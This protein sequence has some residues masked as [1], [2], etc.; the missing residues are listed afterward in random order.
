MILFNSL[1]IF[2]STVG[3]IAAT[4]QDIVENVINFLQI[5]I[6]LRK[7]P[8]LRVCPLDHLIPSLDENLLIRN[9]L[10]FISLYYNLSHHHHYHHHHPVETFYLE[11]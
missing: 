10:I 9:F 11:N 7:H 4:T 8:I 5:T 6:L 2:L 1:V 3:L